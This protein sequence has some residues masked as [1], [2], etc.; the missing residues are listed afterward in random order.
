MLKRLTVSEGLNVVRTVHH[1]HITSNQ[2]LC[3]TLCLVHHTLVNATRRFTVYEH[4]GAPSD[5]S[6]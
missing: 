3:A 6:S 1:V 4:Q 5:N 2:H